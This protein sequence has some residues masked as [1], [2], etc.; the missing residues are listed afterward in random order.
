MIKIKEQIDAIENINCNLAVNAGAGTGKTWVL[1]ERFLYILDHGNLEKN[2]EI[3]SIVAI[4]FTNKATQEMKD[5]I[6][7]A[8]RKRFNEDG[9]W[10]RFYIEMEKANI[11]TIHSFCGNILRDNAL[12]LNLDPSFTILDKE[13]AD[14]ILITTINDILIEELETDE[15]LFNM[16]ILLKI[17][18]LEKIRDELKSIYTKIRNGGYTIE[19]VRQKTKSYLDSI[20]VAEKDEILNDIKE[21]FIYLME[22]TRSNS[23]F[24]KIK[25][26]DEWIR[27]SEGT[28]SKEELLPILEY[29][30]KNIGKNTKLNDTIEELKN[31]FEK[32]FS[33]YEK[34][35]SWCYD[36]VFRLLGKI[37]R[38]YMRRKEEISSLDY[39]D[40]QFLV[41]KLLE[42]ES[43][44]K[45]YQNKYRY[46]M[47]DEFQDTN[48]LQ[49]KIFYKLCSKESL[50]DRNNLF[51]VGDP[52][53]SIYGFRGADL[54]VF[55]EVVDDIKRTS[56]ME[57]INLNRNFRS[58]NTVID[59]VNEIFS[60][61]M[62]NKYVPLKAENNSKNDK[63]VEIIEVDTNDDSKDK[64]YIESRSIAGR[65]RE[66][67]DNGDFDYK[68]F[69]LLFRSTNDIAVYEDALKEYHIPFYNVSG[70]DFFK[71]Q[72]I[73]DIINA[74]KAISNRYDTIPTVGFLRSPMIGVSD[75]A[76]YWLLKNKESSLYDTLEK[77]ID[78]IDEDDKLKIK[79]AYEILNELIIKKDIYGVSKILK[80]LLEKTLY[81]QVLQLKDDG[82]QMILNVEKFVNICNEFDKSSTSSLEDFLNYIEDI[83]KSDEFEMAKAKMYSED[84]NVVKIM[85]IHKSKGLEFQVVIIPQMTKKKPNDNGIFVF[86]KDFGLGLRIFKNTPL[87]N[88]IKDKIKAKDEEEDE[89]ILYVAMTRAKSKLILG[90]QGKKGIFKGMIQ[91][92]I[93]MDKVT[94][95]NKQYEKPKENEEDKRIHKDLNMPN[96][97]SKGIPLL[98]GMK[99]YKAK[100][101]T[102]YTA[103]QFMD[104]IQCKRKFYLKY[105]RKLPIENIKK[106]NIKNGNNSILDGITKGNIV[107]KFCQYYRKDMDKIELLKQIV[108]S[109]GYSYSQRI[110]SQLDR[111]IENY[112][113]LYKEDCEEIFSE[114]E[115]FLNIGNAYIRGIIDRINIKN[116]EGEII[117]F[118]TNKVKDIKRIKQIYEPQLQLYANALKSIMNININRAA[119]YLLDTKDIIEIDISK[120]KLNKNLEDIK[121]FVDFVEENNQ[122]SQYEKANNCNNTCEYRIFCKY[123]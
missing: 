64:N 107:H 120:E 121:C 15:N 43:M 97:K 100:I 96:Y 26:Q 86:H 71:S 91:D 112:L 81:K 41:L 52:K 72:E 9:K 13:K 51:I 85:T 82:R 111:Y 12:Q 3:E 48:E 118:K 59:F 95:I 35:F 73:K 45:K 78:Y 25:G 110:E 2:K 63:D 46:I 18:N 22:N 115:F 7:Q 37:D 92:H 90:W 98:K 32:A 33:I 122:I 16:M 24:N 108:K 104:F 4:T 69:C 8:I 109:Y 1:T 87:V 28:Y 31:S 76:I 65:I 101:F 17:G 84:A 20:D 19:Y 88:K 99:S 105:Y 57:V 102:N 62:G 61:V 50:L 119:I 79:K 47:I 27:F 68:D 29:L 49:K 38:E 11:S 40:L 54:D 30:Y 77:D 116:G 21:K 66:L 74:L 103:T 23:K 114:K 58:V 14:R 6:R 70:K 36:I 56:S 53:Q 93:D 10:K 89:R 113:G 5:R 83:K 42:D 39:E 34:D 123:D 44:R 80:E 67:V 117:D 60:K 106:I 94:Y 55:Y 75:E